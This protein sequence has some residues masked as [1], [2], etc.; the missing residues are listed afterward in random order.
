MHGEDL[1]IDDCGD[2]QAVETISKCLPQLDVVSSFAFIV[3]AIDTIDRG[4]FVIPSQD[5]EILGIFDLVCKEQTDGLQGLF[6]TIHVVAE[7]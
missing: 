1:L 5:E 2:G 3:E 6:T 7:E 4:T